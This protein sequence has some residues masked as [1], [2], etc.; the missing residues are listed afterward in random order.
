MD[1]KSS[2]EVHP[3][4]ADPSVKS[5][6]ASDYYGVCAGNTFWNYCGNLLLNACPAAAF[7]EKKNNNLK[8]LEF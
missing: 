8:L 7:A 5:E 2:K 1:S 4:G 6:V 3:G